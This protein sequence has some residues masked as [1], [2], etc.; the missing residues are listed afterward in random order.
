MPALPD[1]G[2]CV[3]LRNNDLDLAV[4]IKY[5]INQLPVTTQWKCI[6]S[7]DYALGIEPANCHVEGRAKERQQGTLQMLEPF[8]SAE[9]ELELGVLEGWEIDSFIKDS[10]LRLE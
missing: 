7:G 4:Y 6:A 3:L 1:G 10:K 8:G 9:F 2:A 5:N